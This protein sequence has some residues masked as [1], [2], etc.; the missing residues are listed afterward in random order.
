M[1]KYNRIGF[2]LKII[3]PAMLAL[4]FFI[5]SLFKFILPSFEK[6][7]IDQKGVMLHELTNTTWSILLKY[8][9]DESKGLLSR[10]GAQSSAI[11]EI[12]SLRYG[13]DKKDYFWITDLTPI[14][15]MHPYVHELEGKDLHNFF[16]PD[17][18][19]IFIEALEIA[20]TKG[21]G[22]INYKW[23]HKDDSLHIVP[24]MSFVKIFEPW[25]WIIGTGI[26]LDDIEEEISSLT[27]KMI[28]ILIL[29]TVIISFIISFI[30]YQSLAIDK[31]RR[32]A[33]S[34]LIESKEKYRSLV[35]SSTEGI[36]LLVKN[37]ISYTNAFIQKW[38]QYSDSEL[39]RM[40]LKDIILLPE[41]RSVFSLSE[42]CNLK[43]ETREEITL[44]CKDGSSQEAV[45]T[46]MPIRYVG[47][48]G[49]LLTFHDSKESISIKSELRD[50]KNRLKNLSDY[51]NIGMFRFPLKG[52]S[53]LLEYNSTLISILGYADKS[54]FLDIPLVDIFAHKSDLRDLLRDLSDSD[55]LSREISL[56]RRDGTRLKVIITLIKSGDEYCDGIAVPFDS[57][58]ITDQLIR[59]SHELSLET[60]S[61]SKPVGSF[62]SPL[63]TCP[64]YNTIEDAIEIMNNNNSS[65][66]TVTINRAPT[67]V[68]TERDIVKNLLNADFDKSSH[69]A[70]IMNSPLI[71]VYINTPVSEAV[72]QMESKGISYIFLKNNKGKITSI[73]QK[74]DIFGIYSNRIDGL[75]VKISKTSSLGSLL[76][77]RNKI[78]YLTEPLIME[79]SNASVITKIISGYN[80]NI[81]VK[82][83]E[84]ALKE[85]GEPPAPFAF[86]SLGSEGREE[87]VFSSDQDNA[88][89]YADD[90]DIDSDSV[91]VYFLELSSKICNNLHESGLQLCTGGY[92][93][94]NPKWCQPLSVWKENFSNWIVNAEP[95]NIM[96]ISVFFDMRYVFGSIEMFNSLED[97]IYNTLSG[98]SAFFY[99]L[100]NS[101]S[102]FKPPT[103]IF[104]N[105]VTD[106]T[107]KTGESLDIKRAISQI[108]MFARIYALN[109]NI[110]LKGTYYR[111]NALEE[112]GVFN[113]ESSQE[114]AYHFNFLSLLR[115]R[116]QIEQIKRKESP[117]STILP[118]NLN[119][120]E[121]VILKKIFSQMGSYS[122][123]LSATFMSSF[124]G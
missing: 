108:V 75:E 103:N 10:E 64:S 83:I 76:S 109:N 33:E 39:S 58:K 113:L 119:S 7:A 95:A 18:K 6:T 27:R 42:I 122:E 40:D 32:E 41:K 17:G 77:I 53:R 82:I 100:A 19:R 8:Q 110:R 3:L 101:V 21:E 50:V 115:L 37:R 31:R 117:D 62:G 9:T 70:E 63:I 80:D 15:I 36:I 106:T 88:L 1:K 66:V 14:M 102:N 67:G 114:M 111:I 124:K 61:N 112:C 91:R 69:V 65:Y 23:Q 12:E 46:V 5:F 44:Q 57:R 4:L 49:V 92:M 105:I 120:I 90:S 34:Q 104:G 11:A 43:E 60:T 25:G 48:E 73:L 81:I 84:G 123:K 94:S 13:I 30:A 121:I 59:F 99:F 28:Y 87:L 79:Y 55:V 35:E 96:N 54:E 74:S 85:M 78:A 71:S 86:V 116:N 2:F 118:G 47:K 56:K 68:V 26:Y 97:Y 93:A 16:D 89:I 45:L 38:L 107:S 29:I 98:K 22:F 52:K 72:S 24:K 51:T 20:Q